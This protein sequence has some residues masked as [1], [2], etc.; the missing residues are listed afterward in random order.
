M[1]IVGRTSA[2]SAEVA[3][4]PP[5]NSTATPPR[6]AARRGWSTQRAREPRIHGVHTPASSAADVVPT[7]TMKA[8]ARAYSRPP[9]R[10]ARGRPMPISVVM[11]TKPTSAA[12]KRH[13]SQDRWT[14]HPGTWSAD[15]SQKN[16]PIGNRYPAAWF[17][18]NPKCAVGSQRCIARPRKRPGSSTRSNLV[19]PTRRPGAC[20][21]H[22][23]AMNSDPPVSPNRPASALRD[24][25]RD[26][27]AVADRSD[28]SPR[29]TT[30]P[31]WWATGTEA[32]AWSVISAPW[33]S[34]QPYRPAPARA[35]PGA[36]AAS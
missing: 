7:M 6:I 16:G 30:R 4:V 21:R 17:C 24:H 8:G 35:P 33:S 20:S 14:I 31:G 10:R 36:A 27:L 5:M 32:Y 19:S 9:S 29:F 25:L 15:P 3:F 28:P 26:H 13:A 18:R 2:A 23:T 12:I 22:T 1:K 34:P 11:R